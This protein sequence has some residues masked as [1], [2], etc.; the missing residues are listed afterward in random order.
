[1]EML[2]EPRP[3]PAARKTIRRFSAPVLAAVVGFHLLA[4]QAWSLTAPK[5]G[6]AVT[7]F[8]KKFVPLAGVAQP[9]RDLSLGQIVDGV[10]R[11]LLLGQLVL[12]RRLVLAGRL[13]TGR[14]IGLGAGRRRLVEGGPGRRLL[15]RATQAGQEL[16]A[17]GE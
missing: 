14:H 1:M 8:Q 3:V 10:D 15:R 4:G 11:P 9:V 16:V 17:A 2:T 5:R 12:D 7:L 6:T 13:R